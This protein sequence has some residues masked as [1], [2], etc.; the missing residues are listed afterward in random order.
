MK[1]FLNGVSSVLAVAIAFAVLS[2][3]T[4]FPDARPHSASGALSAARDLGARLE[5]TEL[6][7]YTCNPN[8]PPGFSGTAYVPGI[9]HERDYN[10]CSFWF[11]CTNNCD[12]DFNDFDELAAIALRSDP[13]EIAALLSASSK[14]AYNEA[15]QAIQ[16]ADCARTGVMASLPVT[17]SRAAEIALAVGTEHSRR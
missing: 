6:C 15:R 17:A 3:A 10:S 8:C 2:A 12:P 5:A 1:R 13:E 7:D 14:L 9:G 11:Y 4:P 16:L